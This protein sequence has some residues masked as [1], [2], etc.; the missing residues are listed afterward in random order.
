MKRTLLRA[1]HG[2]GFARRRWVGQA[3]L[4]TAA[5]IL[6]VFIGRSLPAILP[7][8]APQKV[9]V[10]TAPKV[11]TQSTSKKVVPNPSSNTTYCPGLDEACCLRIGP[12][13][14]KTHSVVDAKILN[15]MVAR[16]AVYPSNDIVSSVIISSREWESVKTRQ[17]HEALRKL[18]DN[19]TFVDVG[20]NVGWFTMVMAYA[21]YRVYAIEPLAKNRAMIQHSL[22]IAP[23]EVR[24]RVTVLPY[25]LAE[26]D[27][28]T[29]ELWHD[30]ENNRGNMFVVCTLNSESARNLVRS[31]FRKLDTV[32]LM[33]LDTL[34]EDGRV[35]LQKG[36]NVVMKMDTEGF[37]P[38]VIRGAPKF[39]ADIHPSVIYSEYSEYMIRRGARSLGWSNERANALPKEFINTMQNAGY[40]LMTPLY[41][42]PI[43][44]IIFSA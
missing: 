26:T 14:W 1:Y 40:R 41:R 13:E 18:G 5:L 22:C 2:C 6:G 28:G 31:N 9:D 10:A 7:A 19:A 21:G 4:L 44:D 11:V 8:Q 17:I 42:R 3:G 27:G 24:A 30:A 16:L 29:C 15:K 39:L 23:P 43:I 35:G 12:V 38:H 33:R 20:A 25:G 37:E 32:N 36:D 34:V